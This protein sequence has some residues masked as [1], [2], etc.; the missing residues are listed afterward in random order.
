MF[1]RLCFTSAISFTIQ[2]NPLKNLLLLSLIINSQLVELEEF[3]Q[4]FT[5]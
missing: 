3:A 4:N 1:Q 2:Q 5:S